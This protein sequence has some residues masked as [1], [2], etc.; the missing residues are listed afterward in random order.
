MIKT[1][2]EMTLQVYRR[3]LERV[4]VFRFLILFDSKLIWADHIN[5]IVGT[6]YNHEMSEWG[7]IWSKVT[8]ICSGSASKTMLEKLNILQGQTLRLCCGAVKSTPPSSGWRCH[9]LL[10]GNK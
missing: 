8:M 4:H 2:P 5:K 6:L 1:L 7:G 9:Q 3:P 10:G